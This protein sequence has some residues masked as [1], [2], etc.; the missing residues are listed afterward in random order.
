MS[1]YLTINP[2]FQLF[3]CTDRLPRFCEQTNTTGNRS[4]ARAIT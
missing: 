3:L 1:G 2:N 4:Y